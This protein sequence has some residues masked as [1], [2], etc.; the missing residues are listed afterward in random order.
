MMFICLFLYMFDHANKYNYQ[1]AQIMLVSKVQSER[2]QSEST[3]SYQT[4]MEG[5]GQNHNDSLK[6]IENKSRC[7]RTTC[8]VKETPLFLISH[9]GKMYENAYDKKTVFHVV[10]SNGKPL[11][12]TGTVKDG[13]GAV[14]M[15]FIPP[16]RSK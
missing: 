11:R 6:N 3:N 2:H 10:F 16:A 8:F 1:Q 14:S 9:E 12:I 13:Q 4:L 5:L 7:L 15:L